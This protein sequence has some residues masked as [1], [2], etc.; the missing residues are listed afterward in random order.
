MP[1]TT[2]KSPKKC[3]YFSVVL[4]STYIYVGLRL[5]WRFRSYFEPAGKAQGIKRAVKLTTEG[6][7][8]FRQGWGGGGGG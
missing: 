1:E 6:V 5:M 2:G 3:P 7:N 4:S 8:V